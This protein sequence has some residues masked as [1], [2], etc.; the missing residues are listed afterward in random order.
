MS[1]RIL[2][3][4]LDNRR[5]IVEQALLDTN[6]QADLT[7]EYIQIELLLSMYSAY[8]DNDPAEAVVTKIKEEKTKAKL[9]AKAEYSMFM[10]LIFNKIRT[11]GYM[12]KREAKD[13]T[14]YNDTKVTKLL[15]RMQRMHSKDIIHSMD[16]NRHIWRYDV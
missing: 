10:D 9:L 4:E 13:I 1:I 6:A 7:N 14:Q 11:Q 16:G 3:R 5:K 15:H 2:R 12:Y 8:D